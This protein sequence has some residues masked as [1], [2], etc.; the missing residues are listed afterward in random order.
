MSVQYV[1]ND[2]GQPVQVLLDISDYEE[3]L[4]R[5]EDTEALRMLEGMKQSPR[6]YMSLDDL[7]AS[8]GLHV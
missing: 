5:I 4:D 7:A 3:L 8:L 2:Q 1:V 6:K